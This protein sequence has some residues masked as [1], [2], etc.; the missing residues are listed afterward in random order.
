M[1]TVTVNGRAREVNPGTTLAAVVSSVTPAAQ[2]VAV[3]VNDSVVPRADWGSTVLA[4]ADHVE[5]LTAV[6]GG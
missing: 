6:Q 1:L 3:A 4:N 5:I 2:G